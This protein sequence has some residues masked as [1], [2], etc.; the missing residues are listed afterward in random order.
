M[1]S[2]KNTRTP[3]LIGAGVVAIAVIVA[4]VWWLAS[5]AT[6]SAASGEVRGPA[7]AP[8]ERADGLPAQTSLSVNELKVRDLA[9][10]R[11][12]YEDAIG[13]EVMAE[14][15]SD[16]LLG[17]G[18][19]ALVRLT[20]SDDPL[21]QLQDAGLYHTAILYPDEATLAQTLLKAAQAAPSSFQGSADHR[22]S[23]A[24]YFGDPE[25]NGIE[26]YVDRPADEWV[27]VDGKV[28][29]GSEALDPNEFIET[30]LGGEAR[31]T[32]TMGHVHLKVGDLDEARKFYADAL[33]F[34][35]VSESDG[36]L[37]YSAGGYHHHLATN[38]WMSA[39]SGPR[40]SEVGLGAVTIVLPD[41]QSVDAVAERA[42]AAGYSAQFTDTESSDDTSAGAY[43]FVTT[44]PWGNKIRVVTA[45]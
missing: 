14:E 43:G 41:T 36:A 37:F 29:M 30:H 35:V 22:V 24:F 38:T 6:G 18:D 7:G 20:E 11:A 9:T 44:D 2:P 31:G 33:G 34:D 45:G 39:G 4:L 10:V 42:L 16:V 13:L 3:I 40:A 12:Y 5:A 21:P 28:T 1:T 25:G 26:L 32:A 23:L 27:W 19:V 15:A 8:T 17:L